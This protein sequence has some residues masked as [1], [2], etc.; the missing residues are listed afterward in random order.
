MFIVRCVKCNML[1]YGKSKKSVTKKGWRNF[2]NKNKSMWKCPYC[3]GKAL[4]AIKPR[5][6]KIYS[7]GKFKR[8]KKLE[9][10]DE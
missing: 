2:D 8:P 1:L 6:T 3:L 10:I 7:N 9:D 5:F 4:R